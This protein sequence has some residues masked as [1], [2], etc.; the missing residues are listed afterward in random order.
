MAQ[1]LRNGQYQ[2]VE[3]E[4]F[5]GM[6][7]ASVMLTAYIVLQDKNNAHYEQRASLSN[8]LFQAATPRE[9]K[10]SIVRL[11]CWW[12][13]NDATVVQEY[14][15]G[16]GDPTKITDEALDSAVLAFWDTVAGVVQPE[17]S[18]E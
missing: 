7:E 18:E 16:G 12:A 1:R 8:T 10:E 5:R 14:V 13:V 2:T 9:Q 15:A 4:T 11:F 6:V 17:G 3:N